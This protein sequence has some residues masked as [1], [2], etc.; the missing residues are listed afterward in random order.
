[1]HKAD[2]LIIMGARVRNNGEPSGAMTRRVD[3]AVLSG[4][5]KPDTIFLVTGGI[6][7]SGFSEA[8]TM[9]NMLLKSGIPE[10]NILLEG[11]ST[12]TIL[13]VKYCTR[14]LKNR[15]DIETIYIIS[16]IYH[17]PRCRW[18]FLL[19]GIKTKS[20]PVISGLKTN[21]MIKWIYYYIREIAAL[22]F[23]TLLFYFY[24]LN[25]IKL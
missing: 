7:E 11:E 14:I 8:E 12:N 23:D 22:P 10:Q 21:G 3:S 20:L 4:V 18:L 17:I 5:K 16:D 15:N 6:G 1:M 13:S 2:C 9:K 24:K 25:F 19:F